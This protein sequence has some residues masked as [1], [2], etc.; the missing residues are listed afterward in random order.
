MAEISLE[1]NTL[2]DSLAAKR[3]RGLDRLPFGPDL[4]TG[5]LDDFYRR[6]SPWY[7]TVRDSL[8]AVPGLNVVV[9]Q[10]ALPADYLQTFETL[11]RQEIPTPGDHFL[12]TTSKPFDR[13]DVL[14]F[15]VSGNEMLANVPASAL[16]DIYVVPDPYIAV[17]PLESRSR[18]L[19]GRGERRID[20]RNLPPR[21]TIRI[22]TV[23]GRLVTRIEHEAPN[24]QSIATWNLQ[25]DDGLDVSYGVYLYH[26]EAPGIGEK[27]GRFAIIK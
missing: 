14:R 22:F 1:A 27:I 15:T 13:D 26:V 19:S 4:E 3:V 20:F 17:N 2:Y 23:S 6:L 21:C 24:D 11:T 25:S 16:D 9:A 10:A 12:L 8:L 7:A 5:E 18:L